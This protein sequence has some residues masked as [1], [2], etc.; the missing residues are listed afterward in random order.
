MR[1]PHCGFL[2]TVKRGKRAGTTRWYC[3]NCGSYFTDRR[4]QVT[5][6][7]KEVWFREW[8]V[9]HQT[10]EQLAARSGESVRTLKRYFYDLLPRCPVWHIQRRERVN[11]LID[12]T[13][14]PNKVCLVLYRDAN[15]KM[16]VFYRLSDGEHFRDLQEDLRNIQQTGIEIESVTCDGAA[17]ILRA[18]REVCPDAILQRCTVHI[19]R[20]IRTWLTRRPKSLP[21]RELL[22]LVGLLGRVETPDQAN[23]WIRAF[24][25]WHSTHEKFINEK[26]FDEESGRWWYTHKMLHRSDTHIRRALPEMFA[27]TRHVRV[28]KSSNSIESFFGHLK[29]NMRIH[30]GLSNEHFRDFVKWYLFLHSNQHKIQK[31]SG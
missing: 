29:D 28:P 23:L 7:N 6:K 26:S 17:N 12:G 2:D 30:R 20:E 25:D 14:F 19:A 21:A 22:D 13:Y 5:A 1:C 9:G 27:Y 3:K 16:T 24:V 15:I 4:P 31:N 10:I 18:V 11:L 8:I